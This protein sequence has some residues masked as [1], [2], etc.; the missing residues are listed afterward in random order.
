MTTTRTTITRTIKRLGLVWGAVLLLAPLSAY[1]EGQPDSGMMATHDG[2]YVTASYGLALPGTTTFHVPA[3]RDTQND[4]DAGTDWGLLGGRLGSATR[5][6]D[7]APSWRSATAR[8]RSP[9]PRSRNTT[10]P[11]KRPSSS[12]SMTH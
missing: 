7:S 1:A 6:P 12:H 2:M 10:T 8:R 3:P 9:P 5:S 11:R 4:A